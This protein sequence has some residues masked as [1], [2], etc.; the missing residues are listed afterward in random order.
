MRRYPPLSNSA[1]PVRRLE[2][3]E[4]TILSAARFGV[5]P[6]DIPNVGRFAVAGDPTGALFALF[7]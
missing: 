2:K 3:G 1:A 4:S 5:Q 6:K 7:K